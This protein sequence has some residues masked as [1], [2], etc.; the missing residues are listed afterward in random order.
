MA[1]FISNQKI[2][3]DHALNNNEVE[4]HRKRSASVISFDL[5]ST[6]PVTESKNGNLLI[7]YRKK[8]SR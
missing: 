3:H 6:N 5:M 4:I 7:K 8:G 2:M 1:L